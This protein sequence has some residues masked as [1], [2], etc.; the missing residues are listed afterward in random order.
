[1]Y[2]EDLQQT[3]CLEMST[4][5]TVT[6]KY[7]GLISVVHKNT[8]LTNF[9]SGNPTRRHHKQILNS[10]CCNLIEGGDYDIQ[11]LSLIYTP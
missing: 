11:F 9:F 4:Y 10:K 3:K 5:I 1:M 7:Q 8:F 2:A 6:C